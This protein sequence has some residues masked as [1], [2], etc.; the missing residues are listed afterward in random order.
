MQ[1]KINNIQILIENNFTKEWINIDCD[2][3]NIVLYT[4]L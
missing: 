2:L 4:L 1:A 3:Y